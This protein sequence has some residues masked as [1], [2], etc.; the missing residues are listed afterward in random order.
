MVVYHIIKHR[1]NLDF[2]N[3]RLD[4]NPNPYHYWLLC[5]YFLFHQTITV[6]TKTDPN[7]SS[8][9]P[10]TITVS[11]KTN[12]KPA[13]FLSKTLAV[14]HKTKPWKP[15]KMPLVAM[16]SFSNFLTFFT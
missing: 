1:F 2:I 8:L 15:Q 12:P 16:T 11:H 6:F 13:S 10:K 3:S 9:H 4:F 5:P 7:T 14:F